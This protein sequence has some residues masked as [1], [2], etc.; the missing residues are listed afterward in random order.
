M[1]SSIPFWSN[2][3][4]IL[5]NKEYIKELY[6]M[7][8]MTYEQKLNAITRLVI[9][10]IIIGFIFTASLK[11]LFMGIITVVVIFILFKT[12]KQKV[13]K[14]SFLN[15]ISGGSKSGSGTSNNGRKGKEGFSNISA[16]NG[17]TI[18]N[19]ETLQEFLKTDFEPNTKLN[20]FANVLLTDIGDNPE[21]KSAPPS[22]NPDVY[23]DITSSTK[24]MVQKLNPGIK[25]TNKQ[26]FGDL[27]EKFYLDQS[28]RNFFSTA[29]TRIANDQGAFSK[30]LYSDMY[31]AKESGIDG[32]MQRVKD[33]P[34][35][36]LY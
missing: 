36:N 33:N 4:A 13:T 11:L 30:F 23:E 15:G 25:N 27:G 20:P 3:P 19:P 18:I 26:L 28:N 8:N 29:N 24:K 22:F 10:L 7:Q 32:A 5:L 1:T 2:D 31:S 17:T 35:Y 9:L 12:Q 16:S 6:P 34:R 14:E 21:R